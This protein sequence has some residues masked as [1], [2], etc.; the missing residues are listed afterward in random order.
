MIV[1]AVG[2]SLDATHAPETYACVLAA[3]DGEHLAAEADRLE[4]AGVTLVRVREP[5][6]PYNGALM[7]VGIR[8]TR[9]GDLRRHTSSLPLLR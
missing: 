9:K 7:A 5:D 1:H 2:E 6:T 8:P 3:R 4:A